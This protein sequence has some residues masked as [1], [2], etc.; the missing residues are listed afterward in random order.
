[1]TNIRR[2][3]FDECIYFITNI[4]FNRI[5]ILIENINI[6]WKAIHKAEDE[7]DCELIAC[8]MMPEHFHFLIK[9]VKLNI[10]DTMKMIK[11]SFIKKYHYKF[12][13]DKGRVWQYRFWD[14]MI[15]DAADFDRH[16]NYIHYN[17]VKHGYAS[18]SFDYPHSSIL[19]FAHI[20]DK[21]WGRK[22]E[23]EGD[24]GE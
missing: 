12:E 3:Y 24:Y 15:R 2:Y 4:T 1:M 13:E 18:S 9:P 17:P 23:F 11:L 7:T 21:D 16:L 5:P 22:E 8:V 20:Y 14:H 6:L 10:S 19:K